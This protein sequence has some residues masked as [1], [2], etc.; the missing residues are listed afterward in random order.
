MQRL[1]NYIFMVFYRKI[2]AYILNFHIE[3]SGPTAPQKKMVAHLIKQPPTVKSVWTIIS[4]PSPTLR[5]SSLNTRIHRSTHPTSL[6]IPSTKLQA[7]ITSLNGIDPRANRPIANLSPG[8]K[9]AKELEPMKGHQENGLK[10]AKEDSIIHNTS[11]NV[12][13]KNTDRKPHQTS[14]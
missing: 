4:A 8:R 3:C 12:R 11:P 1:L 13:Q 14:R 10:I 6:P 5:L 7:V 9:L 2:L